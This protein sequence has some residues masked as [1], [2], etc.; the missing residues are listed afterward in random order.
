M[1]LY[2]QPALPNAREKIKVEGA[3]QLR[4]SFYLLQLAIAIDKLLTS[5][6]RSLVEFAFALY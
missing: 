2:S 5:A 1:Q 3:P 4:R 6:E